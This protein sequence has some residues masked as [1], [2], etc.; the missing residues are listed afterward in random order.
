MV[1]FVTAMAAFAYYLRKPVARLLLVAAYFS[2][3]IT[4]LICI[5]YTQSRGPLIG[6]VAGMFFFLA[7]LGLI[8]RQVWL[9]V[10]GQCLCCCRGY[11]VP[12]AIQHGPVALLRQA[13]GDTLRRP[14]GQDSSRPRAAPERFVS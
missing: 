11:R 9:A 2:I 14:P 6:L 1:I 4:Q 7:L 8:R 5:F 3:L 12:G 10:V 13:A